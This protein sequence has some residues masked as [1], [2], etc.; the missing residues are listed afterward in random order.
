[1]PEIVVKT[2]KGYVRVADEAG[3]KALQ[4]ELDAEYSPPKPEPAKTEGSSPGSGASPAQPRPLTPVPPAVR[5]VSGAP[6]TVY[7]IRDLK[8]VVPAKPLAKTGAEVVA[9]SLDKP[10]GLVEPGTIKNVFERKPLH[11]PDGSYST[12]SSASFEEN[13]SEVLVPTVVDGVR[14]SPEAAWNRYKKT[15]EHLGKFDSIKAADTYA[16]ALHDRQAAFGAGHGIEYPPT[17]VA[18]PPPRSS[19]TPSQGQID[20]GEDMVS[21]NRRI[22]RDAA[23]ASGV[24]PL[25]ATVISY[26]ENRKVDHTLVNTPPPGMKPTSATGLFQFIDSTWKQYGG[27]DANRFDPRKQAELG[28]KYIKKTED[29]I[30][31]VIGRKPTDGEF[32]LMY[33]LGAGRAR[34]LKDSQNLGLEQALVRHGTNPR[35]A[36]RIV[37]S[38]RFTGMTV[39]QAV[40][41]L[42]QRHK[43]TALLI[44]DGSTKHVLAKQTEQ[45]PLAPA[46]VER[47]TKRNA[48]TL[49]FVQK[50]DT[51]PDILHKEV[52]FGFRVGDLIP[53]ISSGMAMEDFYT[54]Y[55]KGDKTGMVLSALGFLPGGKIL[56]ALKGAKA[57]GLVTRAERG[58]KEFNPK[59]LEALE[60][61]EAGL[62]NDEILKQTGFWFGPDGQLR[63]EISDKFSA[64]HESA[65]SLKMDKEINLGDIF[66]HDEFKQLYPDLFAGKVKVFAQDPKLPYS[67]YVDRRADDT[68]G[69]ALRLLDQNKV[70]YKTPQLKRTLLHE[71]QHVIQSEEGLALGA[72]PMNYLPANWQEAGKVLIDH[73]TAVQK[74]N[75]AIVAAS[76]GNKALTIP[77]RAALY[78]FSRDADVTEIVRYARGLPKGLRYEDLTK[79]LKVE[80]DRIMNKLRGRVA[81]PDI[82]ANA[83]K[84]LDEAIPIAAADRYSGLWAQIAKDKY[85][86]TAG[87][88]EARG[89][90]ERMNMS[91]AELAEKPFF[92]SKVFKEYPEENQIVVRGE[93][94]GS[95]VQASVT[96]IGTARAKKEGEAA[97]ARDYSKEER[98]IQ[99]VAHEG[100]VAWQVLKMMFTDRASAEA[101]QKMAKD[102]YSMGDPKQFFKD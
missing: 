83:Q 49:A 79:M 34:I 38:N 11:N 102:A 53:Y 12:T 15:G 7:T 43:R 77:G 94:G 82:L 39:R 46:T 69:I 33:I 36:A 78:E 90:E 98:V 56:G 58:A 80:G 42:E 95:K 26:M 75:Q 32:Y 70:P 88:A 8:D 60:L 45:K 41:T 84:V 100:K 72:N 57:F 9:Q 6:Q 73:L 50:A 14:L 30:T 18:A 55:K 47:V 24:D 23:L 68:Y 35:T 17:G 13:G 91:A 96:H 74:A 20:G 19:P 40:E 66:Q 2:P 48:D 93:Q 54:A 76:H 81:D 28:M 52:G 29:T 85:W 71:L 44:D 63:R 64:L 4:A 62:D 22:I 37:K 101:Y 86:R 99:P 21:S 27:T 59:H 65:T 16:Q 31:A 51:A 3:L 92:K 25:R 67:G 5:G 1:M 87:E 97:F 89:V 61:R 10:A